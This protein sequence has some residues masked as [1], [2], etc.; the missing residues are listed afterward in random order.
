MSQCGSTLDLKNKAMLGWRQHVRVPQK[1]A[2]V[3]SLSAA[4]CDVKLAR[5]VSECALN[6]AVLFYR[7]VMVV[8][9]RLQQI[10]VVPSETQ[11]VTPCLC[12]CRFFPEFLPAVKEK[13]MFR[14][15]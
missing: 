8:K 12:L 15:I 2:P 14:S 13:C 11:R 1:S 6:S 4:V 3:D 10:L 7:H 9:Y 5:E